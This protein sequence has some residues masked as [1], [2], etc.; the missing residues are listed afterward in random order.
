MTDTDEML[1]RVGAAYPEGLPNLF[2]TLKGNPA[3]LAGF[4]A[5][6]ETLEAHGVLSPCERL[7]VG[8][9]AALEMDCAYCRA[10]LSKDAQAAGTP[11]DVI[12]AI[13]HRCLPDERRTRALVEAAQ[14]IL[15]THGR[16]PQA[17][18]AHFARQGLDRAAL[19]EIVAVV[20]EFTIATHANN[21][22]R[23]RIDPEYR[24]GGA[25]AQP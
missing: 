21:L 19:L 25:P 23:T 10:A 20:G 24:D 6:D 2:R 15:A 22:M 13:E 4:V 8:L 17:E 1:A 16:L 18:I 12:A 9:I 3:V 7:L 11:A 5:L 14:R